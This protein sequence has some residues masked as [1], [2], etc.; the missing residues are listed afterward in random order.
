MERDCRKVLSFD[1]GGFVAKLADDA[2]AGMGEFW[3]STSGRKERYALLLYGVL[4]VF[5]SGSGK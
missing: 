3:S 1:R 4:E 2:L 5:M